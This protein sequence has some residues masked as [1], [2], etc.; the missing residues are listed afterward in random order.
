[1]IKLV[2]NPSWECQLHCDYCWVPHAKIDRN[3]PEH[4]WNEWAWVLVDMLP[5][6]SIVDVCGGEPLLYPGIAKLLGYL[7]NHSIRWAV[8]TNAM[9]NIGTAELTMQTIPGCVQ[10]NVSDHNG[11]STNKDNV[12]KLRQHYNVVTHRVN[13]VSAGNHEKQAGIIT[14]QP[15]KEG[16]ACDGIKRMCNAGMY[17][18]VTDPAGNAYRCVVDMQV[19]NKPFGNIF[20]DKFQ[21]MDIP[22]PCDFGCSTCY[23]VN[24][25]EWMVS[26]EAI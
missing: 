4:S 11:N 24:P 22:M 5:Y 20:E 3:V 7:G 15:W 21:T 25:R 1:M 26:M 13:H 19:G 10:I 23:T 18:I 16:T 9:S 14:Y 17:H 6:D 2:I 8:T 12:D